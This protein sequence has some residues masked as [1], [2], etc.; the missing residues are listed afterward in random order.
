MPVGPPPLT[1]S[2]VNPGVPMPPGEPLLP[3]LTTPVSPGNQVQPGSRIT[4]PAAARPS[5]D[6]FAIDP[7]TGE[8]TTVRTA[9]PVATLT[10]AAG[11]RFLVV[12]VGATHSGVPAQATTTG[13]AALATGLATTF[14]P[15]VD[16]TAP[17]LARGGFQLPTGSSGSANAA[18][19]GSTVIAGGGFQ[20]PVPG[21]INPGTIRNP[22]AP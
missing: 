5:P 13:T 7:A 19:T 22:S 18:A 2:M 1:T 6:T 21:A 10:D 16:P 9:R 20:L 4:S 17:P 11:N 8:L 12:S 14:V 15:G 3:L